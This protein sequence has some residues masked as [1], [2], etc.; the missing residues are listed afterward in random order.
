[1][2]YPSRALAA[3]DVSERLER[4]LAASIAASVGCR[5]LSEYLYFRRLSEYYQ[6]CVRRGH[7][8]EHGVRAPR[9]A[10]ETREGARA[11]RGAQETQEGARVPA[12]ALCAD[13]RVSER[14][15]RR[16][17]A[18]I[19]A[20]VGCR[21]LSEYL[22]FQRLSA[23]YHFHA[24]PSI[25]AFWFGGPMSENRARA[26]QGLQ[27]R[28]RVPVRVVGAHDMPIV[29]EFPLHPAFQYLSDTHKS[30]YMRAYLLH[31]HGGGYSD[32]KNTR[33]SWEHAFERMRDDDVWINGYP[34][35]SPFDVAYRP[36]A[37]MWQRL[38]A[39]GAFIARPRTLITHEWFEEVHAL[40]TDRLEQLRAHPASKPDDRKEW[41]PYP[42]EW[43]ELLARIFHKVVSRHHQRAA[44]TVPAPIV[45]GYK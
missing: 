45:S 31:V 22:Y 24:R 11:P 23:Y 33:G 28:A 38:L 12:G 9:G 13:T 4:R 27:E 7:V 39:C 16:L 10:Q 42:V 2:S 29:P 41:G 14:L 3:A 17:A 8:P 5:S 25:T 19:S 43:E 40:L 6:L 18:S 35:K 1:M 32:V 30:D 34:E 15:A 37:K 20:S 44:R 21:S 26:L 36:A